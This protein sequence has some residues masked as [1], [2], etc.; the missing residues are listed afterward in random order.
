MQISLLHA[1]NWLW[2]LDYWHHF[3]C[4]LRH[5]QGHNLCHLRLWLH[6]AFYRSPMVP[7]PS[8]YG[9]GPF[10]R[11]PA[12]RLPYYVL[13]FSFT[14]NLLFSHPTSLKS[15]LQML[16]MLSLMLAWWANRSILLVG[17]VSGADNKD[18]C[19]SMIG[20]TWDTTGYPL[21]PTFRW[22]SPFYNKSPY[23]STYGILSVRDILYICLNRFLWCVPKP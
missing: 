14:P 21:Q 4:H 20:C 1:H 22:E 16:S 7:P 9:P 18:G 15:D 2:K 13:S 6:T 8:P 17:I 12:M 19:Y 5:D 3:G 23:E 11:A 10:L